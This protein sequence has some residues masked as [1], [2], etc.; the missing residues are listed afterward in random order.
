LWVS[1]VPE[2]DNIILSLE[3]WTERPPSGPRLA[4]MLG[5]GSEAAEAG[6]EN[7][8]ATDEDLRVISLSPQLADLIGADP[9]EAAGQAL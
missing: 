5:G 2:D 3:G 8:W 4:A 6:A 1:A 9:G 7:A